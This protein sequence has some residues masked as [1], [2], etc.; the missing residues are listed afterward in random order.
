[1]VGS[2]VHEKGHRGQE[3]ARLQRH[4]GVHPDGEFGARTELALKNYQDTNGLVPD[5]RSGPKTREVLGIQIYSGI[6]I[7]KWN[8]IT[9]WDKLVASGMASFCWIKA[10][11]G[12]SYVCPVFPEHSK[13]AKAM[14]IPYGAYHFARPDLHTDPHKEV[15]NFASHCIP[16]PGNLRP[17][18]DFEVAG[19]H[20]ADSLRSWVATFLSEFETQVGVEPIV[21]TGGN[22]VKYHLDS[23]TTG[24]SDYDLWHAFYPRRSKLCRGIKKDRLGGWKEWSVWQWTGSGNLPGT[25]GEIDRN[26]L[27][28]GRPAFERMIIE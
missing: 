23:D 4:L 25:S 6:D 10:T 17:V 18:L 9:S 12:N 26:W 1:M 14:G 8:K 21:Y 2:P 11:E 24:I 7:S 15:T 20:S 5:G 22:M 28:G 16:T 3:V 27:V 19:D 13:A